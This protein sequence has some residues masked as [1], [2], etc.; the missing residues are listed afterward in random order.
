MTE[1]I[2]IIIYSDFN[3]VKK[4][5]I[6]LLTKNNMYTIAKSLFNIYQF[7]FHK[8]LIVLPIIVNSISCNQPV[9]IERNINVNVSL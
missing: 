1:E 6:T 9:G 4:T 8:I 2:I 3:E 5:T 7:L